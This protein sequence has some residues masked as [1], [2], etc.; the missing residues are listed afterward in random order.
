[1]QSQKI[2]S[3]GVWKFKKNSIKKVMTQNNFRLEV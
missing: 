2:L 3:L 1:M